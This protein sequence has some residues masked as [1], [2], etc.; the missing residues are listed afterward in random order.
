MTDLSVPSSMSAHGS[1]PRVERLENLYYGKY[2][3]IVCDNADPEHLGRLRLLVPSL[4]GGT[5]DKAKRKASND[6][7]VTDWAT[8]CVMA[9]GFENLGALFIPEIGAEVWVEF[10]E[11]ILDC[12]IWV[13]TFW[14]KPGGKSELPK[15]NDADGTEQSAVQDPPTRKII[16]TAKGHSIQFEDKDGEELV[17]IVHQA[18]KNDKKKHNVI[19]LDKTGIT[20]TDFTGN[21]IEMT[22]NAFTVTSKKDFTI[23]ASGQTVEIK[24]STINLTKA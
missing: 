1:D 16:K 12:P 9:G 18:D 11:G 5:F 23:D 10:E 21:K 14:S 6:E 20:L 22:G 7:L 2:R 15:P 17:T 4:F 13:G 3:G 24:A 19:T 8:P